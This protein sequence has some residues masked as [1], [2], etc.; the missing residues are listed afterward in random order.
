MIVLTSV[1]VVLEITQKSLTDYSNHLSR[2][3]HM[4]GVNNNYIL[5][6]HQVPLAATCMK[7]SE[8]VVEVLIK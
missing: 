7:V 5:Y 3:S 8:L 2:A 1:P 4:L 6:G